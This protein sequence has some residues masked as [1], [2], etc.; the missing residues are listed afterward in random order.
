MIP[1]ALKDIQKTLRSMADPEIAAHSIGFFKTGKG[2]YGEGDIFLGIRVPDLR[3]TAQLFKDISLDVCVGILQS[4]YHEER[5][6]GL[7]VLVN[8]FQKSQPE[9][10]ESIY[11]LYMDIVRYVNN[12]DLVDVSAPVIAGGYFLD[13]DPLPLVDMAKSS[14]LWE[15]RISMVATWAFIRNG[16]TD[17]TF[18]IAEILMGD[19]EDL[20]HKAVGWMLR[21]AGKR[22]LPALEGFLKRHYQ[23]MPR[24]MLRYA[25]EKMDETRRQAYL[26]GW[27]K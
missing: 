19:T 18:Q 10:R 4:P 27:I 12:W 3:K 5:M 20:I 16:R 15:R 11:H 6:F 25:I 17:L 2:Q 26:K 9:D 21:E 8:R 24:T 1:V 14:L 23:N 13:K 22:D 7:I